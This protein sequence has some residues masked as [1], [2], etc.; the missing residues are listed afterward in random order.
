MVKL[1]EGNR[2]T[3]GEL[4]GSVSLLRFADDGTPEVLQTV[5][6]LP[7][8]FDGEPWAILEKF[9]RNVTRL[10]VKE[11]TYLRGFVYSFIEMLVPGWDKRRVEEAFRG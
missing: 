11:G 8:G 6:S 2:F 1:I 10:A 7:P 3:L 5:S 9:G 4:D